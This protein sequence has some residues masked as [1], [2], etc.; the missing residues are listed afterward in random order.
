MHRPPRNTKHI[1]LVFQASSVS[2]AHG[3]NSPSGYL[4][5]SVCLSQ[6]RAVFALSPQPWRAESTADSSTTLSMRS[7]SVTLVRC[8]APC[9][10]SSCQDVCRDSVCNKLLCLR[11]QVT[12]I[13]VGLLAMSRQDHALKCAKSQVDANLELLRRYLI[14][15][16]AGPRCAAARRGTY[17]Q[18]RRKCAPR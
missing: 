14:T 4:R 17:G 16:A 7:I 11:L 10:V 8:V 2:T 6:S 9:G 15:R 1:G 5:C 18:R 3:Y 12:K 13:Q